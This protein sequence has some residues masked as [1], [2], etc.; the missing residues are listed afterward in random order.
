[1]RRQTAYYA[2][3]AAGAALVLSALLTS[4]L[5]RLILGLA[6]LVL[7]VLMRECRCG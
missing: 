5:L 2:L 4:W 7:A 3:L 6:L 1:M